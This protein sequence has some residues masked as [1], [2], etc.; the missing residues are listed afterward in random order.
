M[1][2]KFDAYKLYLSLQFLTGLFFSMMFV[3]ASFYEATVA[4]LTGLQLVLVGTTLEVVVLVFEVPTGIVADAYSRRLSIIIGFFLMGIGF[5]VEGLFP[6]FS[7]ILLTQLLWG[8]GYTFTSGATQAWLSDEIGEEN[9]NRAF[10]RGNQFDLVGAL[11]GMLIAIPLGNIAVNVPI[12]VGGAAVVGIGVLLMLFMPENGFKPTRPENRNSF[13]HMGD[14]F[15]KGFSAVRSHPVL[16]S[17]LGIGFI[18]GLYSEGWDRL[19]VKYLVDNFT[20]PSVF[21]MNEV[22]FF[23]LLRAG[24]MLLSILVTR[25]VEKQL[26]ANHAPSIARA[27]LWITVLLSAAIFT[28]AFSPLLAVSIAAVMMVS[29]TRNVMGPLYNAWV[30]QRLDSDTRATVISMSGQV[31][32]IG[33]ITSGPVAALISLSSVRAAITVASLLLMPALPLIVRANRLHAEDKA[34]RALPE[35]QTAD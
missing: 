24:G 33:Q 16:L 11:I 25:Q 31:D 15:K 3:V 7:M 8:V 10:L 20:L 35:V 34:S 12:L 27:M 2:R 30:N 4:G 5:L 28:F 9:A 32:A 21:G 23:G 14:I 29:I 1:F 13:Q 17:V 19:W 26:D 22:A 18:Y 6:V